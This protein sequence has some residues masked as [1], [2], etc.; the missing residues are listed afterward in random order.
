MRTERGMTIL[1]L[2]IVIAI[3]GAGIFLLRSGFRKL[4]KADLVENSTEMAGV[5]KKTSQLAIEKGE[6][7]RVFID[8]D[9][10]L[11]AVE[12]CQ[13][14]RQ[15]QRNE[16]VRPDEEVM[17]RA[18]EKGQER[19]RNVPPEVLGA[20]P[21]AATKHA[22]TIAGHHVADRQ[23][24]PVDDPSSDVEG[25]GWVRP[26]RAAKG[27]K[28]KEIWVQHKD[29]STTKGQVAVYFFPSGS[30]EKAVVE[31]TDGDETF[32]VLVHGLTGRIELKDGTLRDVNDHMLRNALGDKEK[33]REE[34]P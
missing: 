30:A 4:T 20:D 19:L 33:P 14:A 1:E 12:V 9:K 25:K 6:M 11:Y 17:K 32:T 16:Q 34:T 27:I 24:V 10:Q 5:M 18:L 23:C 3:L 7:H 13:G 29:D 8:V 28:F 15:L 26:L 2:M 21:E 31:I 22:L